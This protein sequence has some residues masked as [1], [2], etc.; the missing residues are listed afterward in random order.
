VTQ[1]PEEDGKDLHS[2]DFTTACPVF[3]ETGSCQHGFKCRFLGAHVRKVATEPES[4]ELVKDGDKQ[5][6][7]ALTS[8]EL[9]FIDNDVKKALQKRKVSKHLLH[10]SGA[11]NI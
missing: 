6:K 8:N 10:S 1:E 4:Y 11:E 9:N 3:T 2:I 7:S 5:A